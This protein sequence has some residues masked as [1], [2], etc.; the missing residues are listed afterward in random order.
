MS[1]INMNLITGGGGAVKQK[2]QQERWREQLLK[3]IKF[4]ISKKVILLMD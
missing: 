1:I 3:W 4:K 2:L